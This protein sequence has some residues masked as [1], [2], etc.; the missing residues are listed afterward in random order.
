MAPGGSRPGLAAVT[1]ARSPLG[2]RLRLCAWGDCPRGGSGEAARGCRFERCGGD[3][4]ACSVGSDPAASPSNLSPQLAP[5]I[6]SISQDVRVWARFRVRRERLKGKSK[7]LERTRSDLDNGQVARENHNT[8][9]PRRPRDP[10]PTRTR[11][12]VFFHTS[13]RAAAAPA[14]SQKRAS[15]RSPAPRPRIQ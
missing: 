8:V 10:T 12:L 3:A 13:G 5:K 4:F 1:V 14:V 11:L 9:R 7:S 15:A 2:L 6:K